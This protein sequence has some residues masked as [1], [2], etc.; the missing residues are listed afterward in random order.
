M[1]IVRSF[2]C[3]L[4]RGLCCFKWSPV[5]LLRHLIHT[6]TVPSTWTRTREG[7]KRRR[8]RS[9]NQ[10][11]YSFLL[12]IPSREYTGAAAVDGWR[13]TGMERRG[14]SIAFGSTNRKT[15]TKTRSNARSCRVFFVGRF[16]LGQQQ[17][18]QK[19][20]R[21]TRKGQGRGNKYDRNHLITFIVRRFFCIGSLVEQLPLD[22][23]LLI[24][25]LWTASHVHK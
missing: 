10:V 11:C 6:L 22:R 13:G 14:A 24:F 3:L 4:L 15:T 25:L 2:C 9:V 7:G 1:C 5:P 19:S 12:L 21:G 8:R 20:S 16:G 18:Q 17:Q 23:R